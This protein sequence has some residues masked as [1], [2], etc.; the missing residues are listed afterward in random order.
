MMYLSKENLNKNLVY[1]SPWLILH[2]EIRYNGIDSFTRRTLAFF[3]GFSDAESMR[4]AYSY[5]V[6]FHTY[7]SLRAGSTQ[8]GMGSS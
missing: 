2:T 1:T 6:C 5:L 4:P 3:V 7:G 8:S